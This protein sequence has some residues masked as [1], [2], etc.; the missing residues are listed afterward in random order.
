MEGHGLAEG[1][2][3][4]EKRF[5][6]YSRDIYGNRIV[7]TDAP[8][9]EGASSCGKDSSTACPFRVAIEQPGG[10]FISSLDKWKPGQVAGKQFLVEIKDNADGTFD[11]VFK[12]YQSGNHKI[13]VSFH[14]PDQD[15]LSEDWPTTDGRGTLLH[16]FP[17]TSS[18]LDVA[19]TALKPSHPADVVLSGDG[20]LGGVAGE[21]NEIL[22]QAGKTICVTS[23]FKVAATGCSDPVRRAMAVGG[24]VFTIEAELL[25]SGSGQ[26]GTGGLS[27]AV[28]GRGD[29]TYVA[30]YEATVAGQYAVRFLLDGQ[31]LGEDRNIEVFPGPTSAE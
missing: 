19:P 31:P 3:N 11:A 28:L 24:E 7:T 15:E 8:G 5:T 16:G 22:I 9:L 23:S 6:I 17:L 4:F 26:N 14:N 20:L 1:F 30:S 21:K 2:A 25:S 27:T 13:E 18:V 10:I 29:G 12:F